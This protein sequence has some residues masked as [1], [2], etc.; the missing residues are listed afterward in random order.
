MRHLLDDITIGPDGDGI[1]VVR[2]GRLGS[3]VGTKI[4]GIRWFPAYYG[5]NLGNEDQV[6]D[7]TGGESF[8]FFH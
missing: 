3:V 1:M 5:I 2:C 6:V 8:A 7:V 4:G